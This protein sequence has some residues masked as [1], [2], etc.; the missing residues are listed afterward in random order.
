MGTVHLTET[1]FHAG[2][3]LCMASREHDGRNVHAMHAPLHL[4][5]FRAQCCPDCLKVWAC[6]AYDDGDNMPQWVADI[7]R[8]A[9]P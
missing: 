2:R 1:G 7:R 6:E 3:L 5:T 4:D 9:A 8:E